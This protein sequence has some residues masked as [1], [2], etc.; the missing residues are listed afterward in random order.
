VFFEN[1]QKNLLVNGGKEFFN[2]AFEHPAGFGIILTRF[3]KVS[4]NLSVGFVRTFIQTTRI[5]VMNK[6][7]VE[8]WVQDSIDRMM[9]QSISNCGLMNVSRL[10]VR[11]VESVVATVT[12]GFAF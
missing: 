6:S 2:V 10:G 3:P 9:K 12:V 7:F 11:D 1:I 8:V 4:L 5:G